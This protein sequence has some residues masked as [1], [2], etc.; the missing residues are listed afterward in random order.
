MYPEES[1]NMGVKGKIREDNLRRSVQGVSRRQCKHGWD[2]KAEERTERLQVTSNA[3]YQ[4]S[5][6]DSWCCWQRVQTGANE[7]Y[8]HHDIMLEKVFKSSGRLDLHGRQGPAPAMSD[9][10]ALGRHKNRMK[11]S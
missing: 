1:L 6:F 7:Q 9:S 11:L 5:K 10:G 8:A 4:L 3:W 2:R